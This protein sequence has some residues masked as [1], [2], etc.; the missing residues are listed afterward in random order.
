MFAGFAG[1]FPV[2]RMD[3]SLSPPCSSVYLFIYF[4]HPDRRRYRR[5]LHPVPRS[6]ALAIVFGAEWPEIGR[7]AFK[8]KCV[9][10]DRTIGLRRVTGK[11]FDFTRFGE[12]F[13]CLEINFH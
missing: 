8:I 12:L 9:Q 11:N 5:S 13:T 4:L 2:H 3:P 6:G 10:I 7:K 1:T